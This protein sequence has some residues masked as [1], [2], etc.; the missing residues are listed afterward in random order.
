MA[1]S[2]EWLGGRGSEA[3][4]VYF[5]RSALPCSLGDGRQHALLLSP[6]GLSRDHVDGFPPH[7]GPWRGFGDLHVALH[8]TAHTV[9]HAPHLSRSHRPL[10]N[11][12][13]PTCPRL[14]SGA[15]ATLKVLMGG[16]G[17]GFPPL[18]K[19]SGQVKLLESS[20]SRE[21]LNKAESQQGSC[22]AGG[23]APPTSY[24]QYPR[25]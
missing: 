5:C 23:I 14:C 16:S 7:K 10:Q 20:A 17:K 13:I 21:L 24:K 22:E 4:R 6:Q 18:E 2:W 8:G 9:P 25:G 11:L 19:V 3:C 15:G 12:E 1:T